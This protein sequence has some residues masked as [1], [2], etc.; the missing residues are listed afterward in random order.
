MQY[1]F[2]VISHEHS[3]TLKVRHIKRLPLPVK[4]SPLRHQGS[5][6]VHLFFLVADQCLLDSGAQGASG[7]DPVVD[8]G[9]LVLKPDLFVYGNEPLQNAGLSMQPW[10]LPES[11]PWSV[12]ELGSAPASA[13]ERSATCGRRRRSHATADRMPCGDCLHLTSSFA[14][15]PVRGVPKTLAQTTS[16]SRSTSGA[17]A[18]A[19]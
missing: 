14:P 15:R 18:L 9:T 8:I 10:L 11:V 12:V 17:V 16:K 3:A 4:S 2:G 13:A 1:R 7:K 5:L 6:A 19:R